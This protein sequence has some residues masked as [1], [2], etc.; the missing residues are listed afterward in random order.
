M[1]PTNCDTAAFAAPVCSDVVLDEE[2]T[3]SAVGAAVNSARWRDASAGIGE[4]PVTK[5]RTDYAK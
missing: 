3:A 4:L 1:P 2:P 5:L